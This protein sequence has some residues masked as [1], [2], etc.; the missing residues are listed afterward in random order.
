[1]PEGAFNSSFDPVTRAGGVVNFNSIN[2][3]TYYV[4]QNLNTLPRVTLD[5]DFS[6]ANGETE[7]REIT[8]LEVEDT[9]LAQYR[10]LRLADELPADV[11]IRV[12][13]GGKQSPMFETKNR[14]GK[15]DRETG[16]V[17]TDDGSG[18]AVVDHHMSRFTE[19]FVWEDNP[20]YF[21]VENN[22]GGQVDFNLTFTGY[23]YVTEE[24]GR[25]EVE[26]KNIQPVSVPTQ[27]LDG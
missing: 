2:S 16:A 10:L 13:H 8:E 12:D 17:F 25:Q 4:V 14:L 27:S 24:V 11:E 26:S 15:L 9:Y 3:D 22:S 20:P 18:G 19:L 21:T 7:K 1:M 23:A 6:L 5:E